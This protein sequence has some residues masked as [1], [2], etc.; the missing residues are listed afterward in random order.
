MSPAAQKGFR[1]CIADGVHR[2]DTE[3]ALSLRARLYVRK[4][5]DTREPR[6]TPAKRRCGGARRFISLLPGELN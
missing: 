2:L 3:R 6:S 1:V 4:T 5:C